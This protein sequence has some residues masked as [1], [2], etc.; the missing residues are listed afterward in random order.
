MPTVY[1]FRVLIDHEDDIFRD[2]EITS[3]QTF[4]KLHNAILDAFN[5]KGDQMASFYMSNDTWDKGHEIALL[6][7]DGTSRSSL[8]IME[9][10]F[11]QSLIDKEEGIKIL[12]VFDFLLMWYFYLDL[13]KISKPE[14]GVD[15][16]RVVHQYGKVP[17]QNDKDVSHEEEELEVDVFSDDIFE[18][19]DESEPF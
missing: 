2:I 3:D 4:E 14:K 19:F 12:Y 15:Y 11:L 17:N 9:K 8:S 1:R 5:F 18:G 16:P 10:T 6:D 13:V 7:M